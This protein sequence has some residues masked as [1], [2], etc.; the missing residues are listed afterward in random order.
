MHWKQFYNKNV[1]KLFYYE[2][3]WRYS[4]F[5][6]MNTL[7]LEKLKTNKNYKILTFMFSISIFFIV[8]YLALV[9]FSSLMNISKYFSRILLLNFNTIPFPYF[10]CGV[11]NY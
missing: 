9:Y 6:R 11:I 2:M 8:F 1:R 5:T 4:S 7:N 3:H 10:L